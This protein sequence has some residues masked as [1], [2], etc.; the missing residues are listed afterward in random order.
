[1]IDRECCNVCNFILA[2]ISLFFIVMWILAIFIIA[3][4]LIVLAASHWYEVRIARAIRKIE[5]SEKQGKE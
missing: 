1:M 4:A 5:N 3:Y 2:L